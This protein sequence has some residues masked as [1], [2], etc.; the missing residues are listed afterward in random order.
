MPNN[1]GCLHV[2][3]PIGFPAMPMPRSRVMIEREVAWW[4]AWRQHCG[5]NGGR[6]LS[7][8]FRFLSITARPEC[9]D[10]HVL[11]HG[12]I[13]QPTQRNSINAFQ[14]AKQWTK[15][16][17]AIFCRELG[18]FTNVYVC[19]FYFALSLSL[20]LSH[21][22]IYIIFCE[23]ASLSV[24]L[25]TIVTSKVNTIG[26]NRRLYFTTLKQQ[27]LH[28]KRLTPQKVDRGYS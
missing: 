21:Y 26:N 17:Y 13:S 15:I 8:H 7:Y 28:V 18:S 10:Q 5:R 2:Q 27:G 16:P 4:Q 3:I 19:L 6:H 20:T 23:L 9:K 11:Y 12:D 24:L 25:T 22:F 14:W 1:K